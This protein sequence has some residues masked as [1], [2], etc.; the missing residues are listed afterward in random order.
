MEQSIEIF[1]NF[2]LHLHIC[3]YGAASN[4][5]ADYG[6]GYRNG[7]TANEACCV[8]NGGSTTGPG[9]TGPVTIEFRNKENPDYC[10]DV[11]VRFIAQ[12]GTQSVSIRT[13]SHV[14]EAHKTSSFSRHLSMEALLT[15]M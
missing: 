6:D 9:P 1:A 11:K 15:G 13:G 4:R 3:R 5:C 12:L 10:I 2:A 14:E 7:K 8:C